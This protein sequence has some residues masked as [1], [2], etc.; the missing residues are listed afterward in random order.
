MEITRE[1]YLEAQKIVFKYKK[2]TELKPKKCFITG[3]KKSIIEG[4]KY[5]AVTF[6]NPEMTIVSC[7]EECIYGKSPDWTKEPYRCF[8]NLENAN[9]YILEK[10]FS[11]ENE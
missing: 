6:S 8:S 9:K 7:I 11:Y 2:Q 10:G 1:Q 4:E 3:D 5:F